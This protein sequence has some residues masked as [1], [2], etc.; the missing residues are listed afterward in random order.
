MAGMLCFV[1]VIV[2][3]VLVIFL[4]VVYV[5]V[6]L[7]YHHLFTYWVHAYPLEMWE[8]TYINITE[9]YTKFNCQYP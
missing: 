5:Y 4:V 7:H 6:Y 2:V 1:V 9:Q 8:M 3:A